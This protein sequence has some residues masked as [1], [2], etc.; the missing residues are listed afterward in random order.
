MRNVMVLT[1][2]FLMSACN[3][4][5]NLG[6][7]KDDETPYVQISYDGE[8][9]EYFELTDDLDIELVFEYRGY[10]KVHIHDGQVDMVEADCPDQDCVNMKAINV[11]SWNP[12]IL[13]APNRLEI[14]IVGITTEVDGIV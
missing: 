14:R 6:G 11:D 5:N 2:V 1:L 13:C 12:N 3:F 7:I 9:I 8:V 10:N 4:N